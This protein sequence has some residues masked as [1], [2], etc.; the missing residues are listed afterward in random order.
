MANWFK[1]SENDIDEPRLQYAIGELPEVLN[2]WLLILSECCRHRSGDVKWSNNQFE[3]LGYSRR[4]NVT[5]PK[6]NEAIRLLDSIGYVSRQDGCLKVLKWS[7]KQ[8]EYLTRK[9]R[10]DYR[11]QADTKRNS[12]IVS[13]S[14]GDSPTEERRGEEIR[15]EDKRVESTDGAKRP[16]SQFK[17]PSIEEIKL[18][19]A[20]IGL[21]EQE[22]DRFLNYY[23]SNGWRVGR[24][25]MRS[26]V[27]ALTNWK[28]NAYGNN[29]ITNNSGNQKPVIPVRGSQPVGGF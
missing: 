5:V 23:E 12:P 16:R 3:L 20:K 22:G 18:Q 24:N 25:P 8:G 21:S 2:V 19:C 17:P 4:L 15:V 28:N 26:W 7:E 13:D 27:H 9:E 1:F 14:T 11:K 6:I 10:G 29:H